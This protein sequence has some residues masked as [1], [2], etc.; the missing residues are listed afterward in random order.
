LKT[1]IENYSSVAKNFEFN[2]NNLLNN[3][4]NSYLTQVKTALIEQYPNDQ[5]NEISLNVESRM[6]SEKLSGRLLDKQ[7]DLISIVESSLASF[8][9]NWAQIASE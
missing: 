3:G 1:S 2:T 7:A 5:I 8:Y 6:N 4:D 9:S